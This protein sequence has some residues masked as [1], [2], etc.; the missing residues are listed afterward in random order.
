M[1]D[2]LLKLLEG[3]SASNGTRA[4]LTEIRAHQK[5]MPAE[6]RDDVTFGALVVLYDMGKARAK[7]LRALERWSMLYGGILVLVWL[8]IVSLHAE[9]PWLTGLFER[10]FG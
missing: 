5:D 1:P 10:L 9:V 4:L 2:R 8:T 6:V 7:R 3:N